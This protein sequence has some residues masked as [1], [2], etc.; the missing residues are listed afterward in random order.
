MESDGLTLCLQERPIVY[1]PEPDE[2]KVYPSTLF[3]IA[4]CKNYF[5]SSTRSLISEFKSSNHICYMSAYLMLLNMVF[6]TWFMEYKLWWRN[7]INSYNTE[8]KTIGYLNALDG[9]V[10]MVI[11]I[12][13]GHKFYWE[14]I[15]VPPYKF[16]IK[17]IG[18]SLMAAVF[19]TY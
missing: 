10:V 11:V 4:N 1:Y 5:L 18:L 15:Y 16:S 2:P 13:F 19:C 8:R 6:L 17:I 9:K 12:E 7:K 3:F 14:M